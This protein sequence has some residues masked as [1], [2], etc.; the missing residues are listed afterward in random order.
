MQV[1]LNQNVTWSIFCLCRKDF[2]IITIQHILPT[3]ALFLG[4]NYQEI[5]VNIYT[6]FPYL[7]GARE[8][9]SV[10]NAGVLAR[11]REWGSGEV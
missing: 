11:L 2:K 5:L 8:I 4:I 3:L 7:K 9:Q 10:V 6:K 1:E